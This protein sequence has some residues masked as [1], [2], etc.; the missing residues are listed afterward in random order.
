MLGEDGEPIGSL[1][2]GEAVWHTDMSYLPRPPKAAMLYALKI[3]PVG[4]DT[5]FASMYAA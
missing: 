5:H 2:T 4:G 1:G 3:P